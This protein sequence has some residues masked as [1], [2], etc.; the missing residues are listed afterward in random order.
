[1]RIRFAGNV[2]GE[3]SSWSR[4]D[5]SCY[6]GSRRPSSTTRPR[7]DRRHH[8]RHSWS[9]HGRVD[10]LQLIITFFNSPYNASYRC[11]LFAWWT[12]H[13]RSTNLFEILGNISTLLIARILYRE[14]CI[15]HIFWRSACF[16]LFALMYFQKRQRQLKNGAMKATWNNVT[17]L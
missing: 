8:C 5:F 15:P 1:V 13:L 12:H 6:G 17:H 7:V 10:I 11:C 4:S 16:G 2:A 3:L 9:Q 14:I